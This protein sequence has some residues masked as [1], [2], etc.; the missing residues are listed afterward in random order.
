MSRNYF[1]DAN[2][3]KAEELENYYKGYTKYVNAL[4]IVNEFDYGFKDADTKSQCLYEDLNSLYHFGEVIYL[5][6]SYGIKVNSELILGADY[7][8]PSRQ[9]AFNLEMKAYDIIENY[10]ETRVLGGHMLWPR[11][12]NSINQAK[13]RSP[14]RGGFGDRID[15]TL[16]A[17]KQYMYGEEVGYMLSALENKITK[18]WLLNFKDSD[19]TERWFR[20]FV[21]KM[22]LIGSFVEEE[23]LEIFDLSSWREVGELNYLKN[24]T[25]NAFDS[26]DNFERYVKG[27]LECIYKRDAILWRKINNMN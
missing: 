8:G 5:Y 4:K 24:K 11:H 22:E 25:Q 15:L 3:L 27:N 7:I 19:D 1:L 18:K 2:N 9:Q 14:R 17:I 23:T 12:I 16:F 10:K 26:V 20:N 21:T 13:G 6:G